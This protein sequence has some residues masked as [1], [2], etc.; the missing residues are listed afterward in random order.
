MPGVRA[1]RVAGR[2]DC[3]LRRC[4]LVLEFASVADRNIFWLLVS[5]REVSQ[6]LFSALLCIWDVI[7]C[8]TST[9]VQ[10]P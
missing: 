10:G 1:S 6:R 4:V 9:I 7:T 3:G 2:A 8:A 5:N